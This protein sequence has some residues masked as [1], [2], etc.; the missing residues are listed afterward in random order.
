MKQ[1]A[2]V[3]AFKNE[4]K[5]YNYYLHRISTLE[6]SIEFIYHRLGGVRGID[7][8][9]EPIHAMPNKEMEY[10]LREDIE[11]LEAKKKLLEEKTNYIDSILVEI[12]I[13][14]REA[15]MAVYCEGKTMERVSMKYH[16]SSSG[17]NKRIIVALKKALN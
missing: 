16:L 15:I 12:E 6:E 1:P 13:P 8:S 2:E 9:K 11:C 10:K 14:L 7:P 17:L 5:N 4:L 3:L